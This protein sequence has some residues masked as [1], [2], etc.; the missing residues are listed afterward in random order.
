MKKFAIFVMILIVTV[1][2]GVTVFYFA[3]D[4]EELIINTDAEIFVNTGDTVKFDVTL[5]YAKKG[6]KVSIKSSNHEVLEPLGD[7]DDVVEFDAKEA[8]GAALVEIS[9]TGSKNIKPKY[10]LVNVG[11]GN[12]STP[13]YIDSE[14]ALKEVASNTVTANKNY[15]LLNDISLNDNFV[16][17]NAFSGTFNGKGYTISNLTITAGNSALPQN[18]GLFSEITSTGVVT[19]LNVKSVNI[20][21]Q[22]ENAGTIAGVNKGTISRCSVLDGVVVSTLSG[23]NIGGVCGKTIYSTTS[24]GRIDRTYSALSVKAQ[25]QNS[26]VGGLTG[27]N[28]GGIIINSY[29]TKFKTEDELSVSAK[30]SNVGGIIGYNKFLLDGSINRLSTV[31][32]CYSN[33][34]ISTNNVLANEVN[35]AG[36]IGYN[37]D[38]NST[39]PNRIMGCY[40][41][42]SII[43]TGINDK[44]TISFTSGNVEQEQANFRGVYTFKFDTNNSII[45][46]S[47]NSYYSSTDTSNMVKWDFENVWNLSANV[48]NGYPTLNASGS[49]V[50]DDIAFLYNPTA[51]NSVSKLD[52]FRE[53]VNSGNLTNEAYFQLTDN[54]TLSG[55]FTPIGTKQNPFTGTFDGN[56]YTISNL[57]INST[58]AKGVKYVG[59]FGYVSASA[60]IQNVKI[61]NL[62][63]EEGA[64]H[65]GAIVGYSEGATIL[66]CSVKNT[67]NAQNINILAS[68]SGGGIAGTSEG[69]IK[70]C[71]VENTTIVTRKV[72]NPATE[73]ERQRYAGG[74]A[75][76]NGV[77][78]TAKN[79]SVLN[80]KVVDAQIY[81]DYGT[82]AGLKSESYGEVNFYKFDNIYV[83]IGGISASS[84]YKIE[85]C[86]VSSTKIDAD[87]TDNSVMVA[88]IVGLSKTTLRG[89]TEAEVLKNAVYDCTIK[90]FSAS[91]VIGRLHGLADQNACIGGTITGFY[92]AGVVTD[93]KLG[94]KVINCLAGSV[95]NSIV[96]SSTRRDLSCN[97]LFTHAEFDTLENMGEMYNCFAY[98]TFNADSEPDN[99]YDSNSY[100][101]WIGDWFNLKREQSRMC[102][103]ADY[104][105]FV[106][107]GNAKAQNSTWLGLGTTT[108]KNVKGLTEAEATMDIISLKQQMEEFKFDV[109]GDNSIW[110]IGDIGEYPT[111]RNIPANPKQA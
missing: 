92:S 43:A 79:A 6:H 56:G 15:V 87:S 31:K 48:N 50:P 16:P 13:F 10:V 111:L 89:K 93:I 95:M 105:L 103:K 45:K 7:G 94:G 80:C 37:E 38:A 47:L 74:I 71:A 82:E 96:S 91:G 66:N 44:Y 85:N 76:E 2:L 101:K 63:I 39:T 4:K 23:A 34:S 19:N 61:E 5:K 102:G 100:Y 21:G 46:D 106:E 67:T 30:N 59:L 84:N 97:G 41:N 60:R 11:N 22:F 62:I 86:V 18:A 25:A 29:S 49:D 98:C 64:T 17:L 54:I 58:T 78:N 77:I 36:L 55:D 33:A 109:T 51:I 26:N 3:R 81:D 108:V 110:V 35:S 20:N 9:V 107:T 40:Y 1:S 53:Q 32:N 104:L 75:G 8:G 68:R 12:P 57:R 69:I 28:E 27:L 88:G 90:A 70:D 72:S 83:Y 99:Y 73:Y 14:E 24:T 42:N 52:E 65:A